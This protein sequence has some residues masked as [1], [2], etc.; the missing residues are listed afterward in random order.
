MKYRT[1]D[2]LFED[3]RVDFKGYSLEGVINPQTL[4]K[5]ARKCNYDLGMRIHKT[6][7]AY[8]EVERGKVRMPDDFHIMNYATIYSELTVV[9]AQPQGTWVE[10]RLLTPTD[11]VPDPGTPDACA[12]PVLND[13]DVPANETCVG[14][15]TNDCGED[16]NLIQKINKTTRTFKRVLPLYI[17]CSD[18]VPKE[19]INSQYIGAVNKAHIVDG[20]L[21][22]NFETGKVF[23]NYVSNMTNE[24]GQ[25]MVPNH[26]MINEYYEYALKKRILQNLLASGETV[27]PN[28]AAEIRLDYK[29]SRNYALTIV[30]TPDFC[31]LKK[32]W[33][34]NRKAQYHKFYNMFKPDGHIVG[35]Y[36]GTGHGFHSNP[37]EDNHG[38]HYTR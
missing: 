14:L 27:N 34:V 36:Y 32:I 19:C 8:L 28:L 26:P 4:I 25:L 37:Y 23:I 29:E 6:R 5:I 31:E 7:Q 22:T 17:E 13:C 11:Y 18:Y 10:E 1:F 9:E 20:F 15:F 33:E 12:L 21:R 24:D 35:N 3:V 30:N 2:E 16:F 38:E